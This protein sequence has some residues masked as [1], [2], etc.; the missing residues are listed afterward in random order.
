M[1]ESKKGSLVR[2]ACW[3][4]AIAIILASLV[5]SV[6]TLT[7]P[8]YFSHDEWQKVDD[9]QAHGAS[10]FVAEYGQLRAGPDFGF[11]VRPLG[12]LQ[13]GFSASLMVD[14]PYLVHMVDV[15]IHALCALLLFALLRTVPALPKRLP[16][17]AALVFALSPLAAFSVG[18]VGASFD[19]WYVLFALIAGI[20]LVRATYGILDWRAVVLLLGGSAGAILSKETAVMLPV[21]ALLA[22]ALLYLRGGARFRPGSAFVILTLVSLPIVCYLAIRVPALL[23]S[24]S[25]RAGA[26]DPEQGSVGSNILLYL[27]QPFLQD[28]FELVSAPL[29]PR[30]DWILSLTLHGLMLCALA[31]RRGLLIAAFYVA[32]YFVFLV[33]VLP[34]PIVGAH[35]LYASGIAFSLGLAALMVP[36]ATGWR[37]ASLICMVFALCLLLLASLHAFKIGMHMRTDG[38]C[39]VT[40]LRGLD[41]EISL[42]RKAGLSR[43]EVVPDEFSPAYIAARST[44][45]RRP[46]RLGSGTEVVLT[47]GKAEVP[48]HTLRLR[49]TQQC[50]VVR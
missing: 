43:V 48:A 45:G 35:Y 5:A 2:H 19:R 38:Q 23:A 25:G 28:A 6:G 22:L 31:W 24:F 17:I 10:W 44:F 32:G 21:A 7:N 20:G 41:Q 29:L 15:A 12:F 50:E 4:Q 39:Q 13:Q 14:H 3:L 9:I 37:P 34:V 16:L 11:P 49:M 8:G 1:Q 18:W 26:Y 36:D 33:P 47:D 42:A 40:F 27:A 46:Y 30:Q